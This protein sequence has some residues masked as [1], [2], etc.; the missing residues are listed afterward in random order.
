MIGAP[1]W[2]LVRSGDSGPKAHSAVPVTATVHYGD[3]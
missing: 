3:E 1:L 2:L